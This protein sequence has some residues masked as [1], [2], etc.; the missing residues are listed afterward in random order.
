MVTGD[1]HAV[2]RHLAQRIGLSC[3]RI[4]TGKDLAELREE[5]LWH[6]VNRVD[7]FAEVEPAQKERLLLALKK[8]GH[9]VGF[10]GDGINDA[11]AMH[12]ADV[13]ISV[14]SATDVAREAADFVLLQ[15]DLDTLRQGIV[16]GRK[17]FA[18]TLKYVLTTESAN[19]GNMVSMAAAA[20]F[21]PFLPL[22]AHQVLLNNFLSDIPSATLA[23]DHVDKELVD[24][25]QRWDIAFIRRFMIAFGLLSACFDGLMF[26]AL[27]VVFHA[28]PE[29]FRTG[30]FTAS[31]LTELFV[32]LVLRTRRPAWT[33]RPHVALLV[34]TLVVAVIAV[35]LPLSPLAARLDFVG[36]SPELWG[37]VF[38]VVVTYTITVELAK[39]PLLRW[40]SAQ[41]PPT[42]KAGDRAL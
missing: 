4:V 15:P 36:L 26:L 31:L 3:E 39:R 22:L 23:G 10:L 12:A 28:T 35:A 27:T 14:E 38:V 18:N 20:L 8:T 13:G 17:T 30:W 34:S 42:K 40:A 25:P 2:A 33:S 21:L 9:V 6:L 7:V 19:L 11:P 29:V 1:H 24:Q 5:A 41:R 32:L 16:E 37:V